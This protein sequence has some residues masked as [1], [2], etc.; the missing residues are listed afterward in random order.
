M[1]ASGAGICTTAVAPTTSV[2]ITALFAAAKVAALTD[3]ST[4]TA[5]QGAIKTCWNP[6]G[7]AQVTASP[8]LSATNAILA[9][10]VRKI[11]FNLLRYLMYVINM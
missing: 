5:A 11:N 2:V 1:I 3:I 7:A 8:A 6:A 10:Y 4:F 9:C